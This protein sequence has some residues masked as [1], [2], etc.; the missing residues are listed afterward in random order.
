[1]V[2]THN[3]TSVRFTVDK[4]REYDIPMKGKVFFGQL[5]GMCDHVSY[6]LGTVLPFSARSL[7]SLC[8]LSLCYD[9][10]P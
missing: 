7:L 9:G 5:L 1:M 8:S 6:T 4:M 10:H 2:A 3:E